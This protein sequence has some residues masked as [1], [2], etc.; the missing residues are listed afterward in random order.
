MAGHGFRYWKNIGNIR[1]LHAELIVPSGGAGATVEFEDNAGETLGD[2]G[3]TG[4]TLVLA[5]DTNDNA[6]DNK[7]VIVKYINTSGAQKTAKASY[8]NADSRTEVAFTDTESGG[9]AVTDFVCL[10]PAFGTLACVSSV[11]VQAGDN[12][13]IGATGCVAGIAD[14]DICYIIIAAAATSPVLATGSWGI[15]SISGDEAANQADTGYVYYLEYVTVWGQIKHATWTFPADSSVSTRFISTED[16][17]KNSGT[18]VYCNDFYRR[19]DSYLVNAAAVSTVALDEIRVGDWDAAEF[20]EAIEIG[21]SAAAHTRYFVPWATDVQ[22][23]TIQSAY[24]RY[25]GATTEYATV[26]I[27]FVKKGQSGTTTIAHKLYGG[28]EWT[29]TPK[30]DL[31]PLTSVKAIVVDDA[32]AGGDAILNME[33]TEV[34]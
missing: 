14:P 33:L 17:V 16:T 15:G 30:V 23:A 21:Q 12:V 8:N 4:V 13:C 26:T 25:E 10:D 1:T 9:A 27:T 11:A 7:Y 18:T 3:G 2:R 19:R 20:Y 34:H 22:L 29:W 24:M 32:A 6:Y 5:S 31:Q 28:Q